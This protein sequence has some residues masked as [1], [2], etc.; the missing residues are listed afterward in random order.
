MGF[1]H[2]IFGNFWQRL[3]KEAKYF[4]HQMPGIAD[5]ICRDLEPQMDAEKGSDKYQRKDQ[6][7][8][9][10]QNVEDPPKAGQLNQ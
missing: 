8:I 1:L 6:T 5:I 10:R 3:Y 2:P 4:S 9:K 7:N